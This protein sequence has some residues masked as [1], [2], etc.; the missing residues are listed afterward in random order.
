MEADQRVPAGADG[1]TRR[2][3]P[4]TPVAQT[5]GDP[6]EGHTSRAVDQSLTGLRTHAVEMGG[7]VIDQVGTAVQA[8]LERDLRLVDRR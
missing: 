6:L 8:L 1:E 3:A 5:G 2:D 4:R 7:L